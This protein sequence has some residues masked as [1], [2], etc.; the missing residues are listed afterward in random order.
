VAESWL[1]QQRVKAA[2]ATAEWDTVTTANGKVKVWYHPETASHGARAVAVAKEFDRKIWPEV[3]ALLKEPLPDC[4]ANCSQGGG[5]PSIDI[6]LVNT[7]R[8]YMQPFTCC[9]GSSG[10]AVIRPD[11]S[12]AQI[13]RLFAQ[14]TEFGYPMASLDEY[15]WLIAATSQYAM[16]YVYPRS[17]EDPDYPATNEEHRQAGDFLH[18][19][20]W[21]LETVDGRHERGA[22]LLFYWIDDAST[23]ADVW[24][25]ATGADSLAVV[26]QQMQGG[27][28]EQW[29]NFAIE[30]WNQPPVDYYRQYDGLTVQPDP[31]DEFV[32]ESP[33]IDEFIVDVDHL[34]AYYLRFRFPDRD[35][36][37]IAIFNP[38]AG[39]GD[40]DVA[41]GAI[42]KIDG[43]WRAPQDWTDRSHEFFCRDE[44]NQN[45]EE[46]ILVISDSNWQDRSHHLRTD[47]GTVHTSVDCGGQLSGT[48]T[49]QTSE[50][51]QLP[52]GAK[53][54]YER[55][56]VLNVK[57]RYDVEAEEY[58][59]D[60]STYSHSG[61]YY[62]EGRD[63]EGKLGYIIEWQESGSGD[64][65]ADGRY[66][67]ASIAL[68]ET[69]PDELWLGA[70]VTV[71]KVGQTTY[72]PSGLSYPIDGEEMHNPL[73]NHPTGLPGLRNENGVFD[74]S[75]QAD[76]T[77]VSGSL[78][79]Q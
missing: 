35:L 47:N 14:I 33:G 36:K 30:N 13:V 37:R 55:Q 44:P 27:F 74:M 34:T 22:Y 24:S 26:D 15:R 79:L 9:Q 40:P 54:I 53:T 48:V 5:A 65:K 28:R 23:I 51:V 18:R 21:P 12:F 10:F 2:G 41:L 67:R 62:A 29:R 3:V 50:S 43:T 66:I 31:A 57:L 78:N 63:Q 77:R 17:N 76:N 58:V 38:I 11:T 69:T 61:S 45:L 42:M 56:T 39:A 75:C 32:I 71:R 20:A 1:A 70:N 73:C 19:Q 49:W 16:H 64:F 46:L 8:P 72:Y 6:Y 4:G 25:N 68:N 7:A 60:G 59:D 52:S